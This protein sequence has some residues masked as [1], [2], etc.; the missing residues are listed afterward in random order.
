MSLSFSLLKGNIKNLIESTK[1]IKQIP[2]DTYSSFNSYINAFMVNANVFNGIN[3]SD[4]ILL[5][6]T[7]SNKWVI[8]IYYLYFIHVNVY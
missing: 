3:T 1:E 4:S 5:N 2:S 8:Y 6:N 7:E